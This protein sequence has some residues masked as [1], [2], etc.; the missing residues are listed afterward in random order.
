MQKDKIP[1]ELKTEESVLVS[2]ILDPEH[3]Q[4]AFEMLDS[5]DFYST[6][7]RIVFEKCRELQGDS[8]EIQTA[9]IFEAL[10]DSDKKY[11]KATFLYGLTDTVPL[12]VNIDAS[13]EKLK[14]A[15]RY[16]RA[17]EL[18]R[19][20]EKNAYR[21]DAKKIEDFSK[22]ILIESRESKKPKAPQD[23]VG[24]PRKFEDPSEKV[25]L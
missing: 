5:D 18:A 25:K 8:V 9:D 20:I 10:S 17:I 19:A 4:K 2:I 6:A 23:R 12:A 11:V 21:S 22:Q 3:R 1:Q 16:R 24:I 15:A 13:I 7:N 14:D